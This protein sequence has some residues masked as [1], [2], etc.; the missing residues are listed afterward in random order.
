MGRPRTLPFVG[1]NSKKTK[2][3]SEH[4]SGAIRLAAFRVRAAA[5]LAKGVLM[6]WPA[7]TPG[8]FRAR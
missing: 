6:T 2:E 3:N 7:V 4:P 1:M 8:V 5:F